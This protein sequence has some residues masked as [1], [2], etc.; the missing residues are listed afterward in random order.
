LKDDS[1]H[2]P[3]P[4]D[5]GSGQEEW[6]PKEKI[7]E[8]FPTLKDRTLTEW[9][10]DKKIRY[11]IARYK[12]IKNYSWYIESE[13][14]AMVEH[15]DRPKKYPRSRAKYIPKKLANIDKGVLVLVGLLGLFLA[16]FSPP[17]GNKTFSRFEVL[18][19]FYV[20]GFFL[21]IYWLVKLIRY[22]RK[23]FFHREENNQ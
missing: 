1:T 5:P 14:R 4:P 15:Q 23:R 6:I 22:T 18:L 17:W 13:V 9:R 11:K 2:Q 21:V 12:N 19:P 7:L 10:S 16:Y 8:I 20:T 3:P